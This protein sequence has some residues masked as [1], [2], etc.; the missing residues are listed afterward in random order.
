MENKTQN[1][2]MGSAS[3]Q[4]PDT[5]STQIKFCGRS[6]ETFDLV[7][8]IDNNIFV[9]LYGKS[10]TGKTSLLNAGIFP[11]L[12]GK[13]YFPIR[14]R[15]AVDA[16]DFCFQQ[17][18]I[19]KINDEISSIGS[20]L[21][22]EVVSLPDNDQSQEYLW[23]FFARTRFFDKTGHVIFPVIVLDQ[24]EEVFRDRRS[25]TEALLRQIYFLMDESHALSDRMLNGYAYSYDFNFRFVISIRED[26]LFRLEDIIDNN[27]LPEMKQCRFRL[28]HLSEKGAREAILIPG[29]DLFLEEE[30]NK[31]ADSII[32]IA[33]EGENNTISSIIISIVCSRIFLEYQRTNSNHITFSIV[34][35][36]II[37]NPFERLY[38]EATQGFSYREKTFIE[39]SFVDSSER[40][41]SIPED[42]FLHHV[43]K[44]KELI[45]GKQKILQRIS[46]SSREDYRIELIHDSF[47]HPIKE[48]IAKRKK[49]TLK[50]TVA[51][52]IIVAI[53]VIS[54]SI[55]KMHDSDNKLDNEKKLFEL[56]ENALIS[57]SLSDKLMYDDEGIEYKYDTPTTE[58]IDEWKKQYHDICM[59]KNRQLNNNKEYNIPSKMQEKEPCLVYLILISKSLS[60]YK[61]K[62]NWFDLYS[63]MNQAQINK[64][65]DILYREKRKLLVIDHKYENE[66]SETSEKNSDVINNSMVYIDSTYLSAY[67]DSTYLIDGIAFKY[68]SPTTEQINE[69]KKQ[70]HN[71]CSDIIRKLN[72]YKDYN[73]PSKMQEKEPCLVYLMLTAESLSDPEEKQSWFDLYFNMDQNQMD[74]L[75]KILY[76]EKQKLFVIRQIYEEKQKEIDMKYEDRQ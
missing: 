7:N 54:I 46:T 35:E 26:D 59:E 76:K 19:S 56:Q 60:D 39:R 2:W 44:G 67:K 65:Y 24:F 53:A 12:R 3:Y 49:R 34:E 57:P 33:K 6:D 18:I 43:K 14:I 64:L 28:R 27:Y 42:E 50:W 62:Q 9:T 5:T 61:D 58:Q 15:L 4:D 17:C 36:F 1:P 52:T 47:C 48:L 71:L 25:E 32:N 40:R 31:I 55:Y 45:E 13:R 41:N 72:N 66:T 68:D 23:S 70:Y 10:G 29:G 74:Q 16:K 11:L 20:Y 73:I 8:L 51:I 22:T 75:Y 69:W 30:K 37:G 21:T 63:L 38:K